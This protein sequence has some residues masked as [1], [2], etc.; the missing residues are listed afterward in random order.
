MFLARTYFCTEITHLLKQHKLLN[1][2]FR[3]QV[4]LQCFGA[5]WDNSQGDANE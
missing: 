3:I 2:G 4:K 1:V 5:N